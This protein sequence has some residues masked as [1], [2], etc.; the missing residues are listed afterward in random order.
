MLTASGAGNN[1]GTRLSG[2][3]YRE[4]AQTQLKPILELKA[5]T[6]EMGILKVY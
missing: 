5:V 1:R 4:A 3:G 2:F 6:F